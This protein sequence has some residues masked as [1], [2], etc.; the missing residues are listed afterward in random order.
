[1]IWLAN[2]ANRHGRLVADVMPAKGFGEQVNRTGII[3]AFAWQLPNWNYRGL[4][5]AWHSPKVIHFTRKHAGYYPGS[6]RVS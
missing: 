2:L 3:G 4:P 6:E 1:M 5:S